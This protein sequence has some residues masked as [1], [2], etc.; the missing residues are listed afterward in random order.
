MWIIPQGC[1]SEHLPVICLNLFG[2]YMFKF[3]MD[4]VVRS[5]RRNGELEE[6]IPAWRS[7]EPLVTT[8]NGELPAFLLAA[9]R[10]AS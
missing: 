1:G 5:T 10:L 2:F 9:Q 3:G 4:K 8:F 6:G 7:S